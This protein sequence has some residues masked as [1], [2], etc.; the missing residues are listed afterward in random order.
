MKNSQW[1]QQLEMP[2]STNFWFLWCLLSCPESQQS[3]EVNG[4]EHT[5]D[6][7]RNTYAVIKNDTAKNFDPSG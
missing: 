6:F 5:A 4:D 1:A 7:Q 2:A 3:T